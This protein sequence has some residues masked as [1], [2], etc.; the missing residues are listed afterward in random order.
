MTL[1]GL[2]CVVTGAGNGIGREV[3]LELLR[4]G[5]KVA[6]LDINSEWLTATADLSGPA[7]KNFLPVVCDISDREAVLALPKKISK[8]LGEVSALVNVAGIIQPFVRVNDLEFDAI[9]K[10]MAVNFFGVVN[11][12]K[13]FL[14][15]LLSQPS[16]HL[17]NTSSMG[18]YAPVPGQTV[19]GASKAAVNLL[20][21]GLRSELSDTN[22][23]VTLIYP[24]AIGT[25]IASNSGLTMDLE[26][27][28]D[29][30]RKVVDAADAGR[31]IVDAMVAKKKRIFIGNDAKIMYRMH[32]INQD[33]AANAI[34]KA[35]KDL[36]K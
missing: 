5:A 10:V 1:Q 30:Q 16:A 27:S 8:E 29:E 32:K 23:A 33:M 7:A 6:G 18:S 2:T 4:R 12:I 25:N 34:N 36:L 31:M 3:A 35:M 28:S 11:L 22:V 19:Y 26:G 21:E 20:S 14:P 15:T 24:G 13:A 17:V 9:E